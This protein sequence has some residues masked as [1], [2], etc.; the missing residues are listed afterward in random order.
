MFIARAAMTKNDEISN[1]IGTTPSSV[2]KDKHTYSNYRVAAL[3]LL[4]K[5]IQKNLIC[6]RKICHI[7]FISTLFSIGKMSKNNG[8]RRKN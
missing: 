3:L 1:Q 2:I 8:L 4:E 5:N 6:K 7:F